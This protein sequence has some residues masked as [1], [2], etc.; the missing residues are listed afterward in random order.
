MEVRHAKNSNLAYPKSPELFRLKMGFKN[1]PTN[2]YAKNL[3]AF[4][5][6]ISFKAEMT[7]KD[8]QQALNTMEKK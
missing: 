5:D 6:K 2:T 7:I 4:L 8:F 1:L 3:C